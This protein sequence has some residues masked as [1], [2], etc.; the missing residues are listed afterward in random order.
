MRHYQNQRVNGVAHQQMMA[1]RRQQEQ[2]HAALL[3]YVDRSQKLQT[4][5]KIETSVPQR[6][7]MAQMMKAEAEERLKEAEAVRKR[8]LRRRDLEF[9]TNEVL[10]SAL[11]REQAEN[12]RKEREILRICGASEELKD[13]ENKL[14]MAYMNKERAAQHEERL[15]VE[16]R[17]RMREQAMEAAMEEERYHAENIQAAKNNTKR[18]AQKKQNILLQEQIEARTKLKKQGEIEAQRDRAMVEAIVDRIRAEDQAEYESKNKRKYESKAL[19]QAYEVQRKRELEERRAKEKVEQDE[20]MK[21]AQALAKREAD[22]IAAEEEK[23]RRQAEN[24]RRIVAATE[25]Q[26]ASDEEMQNLR[27]MLWEEEMEAARMKQDAQR[28]A[29]RLELKRQMA[30]ANQRQLAAKKERELAEKAAE[31][32]LVEAMQRKFALD[33]AKEQEEE[34]KRLAQKEQYLDAIQ[35]Q[36]IQR[37]KLYEE[38][39]NAELDEAGHDQAAEE[40]RQRVVAEARRRLIEQHAKDLVGYLPKGTLQPGDEAY[41]Q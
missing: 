13:L 21:H 19:L 35:K 37:Q 3:G 22:R 10:V 25:R 28:E 26:R 17:E 27:D 16:R 34:A 20:I 12:Q 30:E 41:L 9:S 40:Y 1:Q 4:A 36:K 18:Q 23:K 24:F 31:Q 39:K 11:E 5:A 6:R 15:L 38:A 7:R 14:K 2:E 32:D 33:Q 29:R 8:D